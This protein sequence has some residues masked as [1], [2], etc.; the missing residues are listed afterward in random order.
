MSFTVHITIHYISQLFLEIYYSYTG[1]QIEG[2]E[3]QPPFLPMA[4]WSLD[5]QIPGL[6][7]AD[8]MDPDPSRLTM[9]LI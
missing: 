7:R 5:E 9:S 6:D 8:R 2:H 1:Q 3:K 4:C